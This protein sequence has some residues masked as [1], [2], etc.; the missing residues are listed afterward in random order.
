MVVASM[1]SISRC[2]PFAPDAAPYAPRLAL[3]HIFDWRQAGF[4]SFQGWMV[5]TAFFLN[6]FA[7]GIAIRFLVQ[8]AKKCLDFSSTVYLIHFLAVSAS[9]GF[10]KDASW[11]LNLAVDIAITAVLSEWLCLKQELKEIPLA[12]IPRRTGN[13]V[14]MTS[15]TIQ[16]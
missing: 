12:S 3:F 10:P 14:E 1:K 4:M 11:W 6:A 5:C 2:G 16:R 8:R 13:N 15:V 7:I 9:S